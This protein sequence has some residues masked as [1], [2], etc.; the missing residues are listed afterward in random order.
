MIAVIAFVVAIGGVSAFAF[1]PYTDETEPGGDW[2]YVPSGASKDDV[3]DSLKSALGSSMGMR[4]YILWNMMGGTPV[5]ANGAYRV[6]NGRSV[7]VTRCFLTA[8]LHDRDF[9]LHLFRTVMSFIG[10]LRRAI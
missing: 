1:I 9:R 6:E 4:V 5:R 7:H 8:V 2:V 3:R 10:V